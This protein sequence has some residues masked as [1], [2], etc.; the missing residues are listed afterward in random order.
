MGSVDGLNYSE[1]SHIFH[2]L[3]PPGGRLSHDRLQLLPGEN[4]LAVNGS[5]QTTSHPRS[6][7]P[8]S[9]HI[10]KAYGVFRNV[11]SGRDGCII[12]FTEEPFYLNRLCR[13]AAADEMVKSSPDI[14]DTYTMPSFMVRKKRLGPPPLGPPDLRSMCHLYSVHRLLRTACLR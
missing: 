13:A 10:T 1:L 6:S 8:H 12:S 11:E 9:N 5:R 2:P 4:Y 3:A 7:A 14:K